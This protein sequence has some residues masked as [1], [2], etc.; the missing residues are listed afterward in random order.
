M[1]TLAIIPAR[2]GSKR[3]K[4]KNIRGLG[5]K[6]LVEW[7]IDVAKS[8]SLFCDILVS[9]DSEKVLEIAHRKEIL[10]PWLRPAI[11]S[12]D[13]A[14]SIDVV[15][16]ALNWY[17]S[18][19]HKVDAVMLLQPTSPFRSNYNINLAIDLFQQRGRFGSL[20]S[21]SHSKTHPL[22]SYRLTNGFL[23]PY[24]PD[25]ES[26]S[27]SQDLPEALTLNGSIYLSSPG[28]LRS[29]KTFIG[30]DT[31]PL[32]INSPMESLDIDDEFDWRLAEFLLGHRVNNAKA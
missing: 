19:I 13:K 7:T 14:S 20:V 6:P 10:A 1:K 18:N 15:L 8:S 12:D 23:A 16:H 32:L 30:K 28:Y 24:I 31:S 5:G 25:T 17:E 3:I 26:V 22:W 2:A 21:V 11:L 9:T 4:N 27:R 29:E